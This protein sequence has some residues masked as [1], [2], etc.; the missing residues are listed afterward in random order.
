[1]DRGRL[2]AST[3][4]VVGMATGVRLEASRASLGES[5]S[6]WGRKA[7]DAVAF[8]VALP[9]A[10]CRE[11]EVVAKLIGGK[12]ME[13]IGAEARHFHAAHWAL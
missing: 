5:T 9:I 13:T 4:T 8:V 7:K 1:M 12:G 10:T 11:G 6:A 3:A 2:D